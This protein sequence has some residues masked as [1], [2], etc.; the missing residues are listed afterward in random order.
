M[1]SLVELDI[2]ALQF[3]L[4]F[5]ASAIVQLISDYQEVVLGKAASCASD[6][7]PEKP[8]K[9]TKKKRTEARHHVVDIDT[10]EQE[11]KL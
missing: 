3:H 6:I 1:I 5:Q 9:T 10:I 7:V 11:T 8:S 2:F 4:M